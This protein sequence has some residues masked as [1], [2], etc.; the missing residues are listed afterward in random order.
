MLC[1]PAKTLESILE[2]AL[3]FESQED[4]DLQNREPCLVQCSLE[5]SVNL[6]GH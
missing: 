3:E 2:N 5:L 1:P 4:L 6:F